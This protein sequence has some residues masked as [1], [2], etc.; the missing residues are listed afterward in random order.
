MKQRNNSIDAV[1]GIA[2][3]LVMIGHVFV[4]NHM[5]DAYVYDFIKAVQMPL[6]M[7]ISGYLCGQG[8]KIKDL[9]MYGS[10]MSKRAIAY[11]VPVFAWLAIMHFGN[12]A[13]A[14]CTIFFQLDYGLW[15]LAV[16]FILTFFVYTAQLLASSWR[17]KNLVLSE[18]VFWIV[19]GIFCVSLV[20]QIVLGNTFLSPYLVI[21]Y[22]P[23]YIMGYVVGNYGKQFLCW[24]TKEEGKLDCK[25]SRIVQVGI[26]TMGI[27]FLYL[28]AAKN[29]NSMETKFDILIQ[30]IASVLGSAAIIYGTLWW[31]DGKIKNIFAK[32]GGYTLEIYVIH[33][34]FANMLN[35]HDKQYNFY[36]LEGFVFVLTSFI[37]MSAVTFVFIWLMK[38]IRILDFWFFGKKA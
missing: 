3:V 2:I 36:T 32:L 4:H 16:L 35:F 17:E 21:I 13:E 9:K 22:V 15:F 23:F 38:K 11:L 12:L 31:K 8:K 1:K 14:F 24:G 30:M 5:E 37:A 20:A 10:V 33:Y 28:A 26:A 29:L 25:N 19:Y 7:I 6:F 34:H 18:F 27:A